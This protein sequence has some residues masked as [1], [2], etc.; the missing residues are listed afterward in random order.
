MKTFQRITLF[1][2]LVFSGFLLTA[3]TSM[4]EIVFKEDPLT[5]NMHI[6]SD[7]EFLFTCNGG[8]AD[9]G[10]VSIFRL[11]GEKIGSYSFP[12]DMRSIMYNPSD[13][14]LYISTY[15]KTIYRIN[16]VKM[17][18]YVKV[19]SFDE[20][21]GQSTPAIDA[22]GK[23]FWF[24]E[25][26]V[27]YMYDIKKGKLKK[28]ISGLNLAP[29]APDQSVAIAID[30]KHIYLWNSYEQLILAFDLKGKYI[31]TFKVNQGDYMFSLSTANG[32]VWVSTDGNYDVGTWYGYRF[33]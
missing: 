19:M 18:N 9:K 24:Y 20:R 10:Q 15:D 12:L 8:V 31:T 32:M 29:H 22:K 23:Y 2:F 16:D 6:A 17:G 3:Q 7:G 5:H 14:K 1:S 25:D 28:K 27:V 33:W 11:N 13:K 30:K 26:G 4:P 21:D